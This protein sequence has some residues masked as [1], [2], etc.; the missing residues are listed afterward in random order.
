MSRRLVI[1]IDGTNNYPN[2]GYTNVQ[3]MFR[4]LK[5]DDEQLTYYQ[6]GAGTIEPGS[7]TTGFGR[8]A[9]M[10]LDMMSAVMLRQHVCAA[11]RYLMANYAFGDE[12]Y[13]FGF[14]RGA[15]AVRV[16][17]GMLTKV[18]LLHPGF[19]ELVPYA[20]NT[21]LNPKNA[22]PARDFRRHYAR[23]IDKIAFLGLFD[24]VSAVGLPW[25]PKTFPYTFH[26]PDVL[27]VRHA[28]ALDEHRVMF[29]QNRWKQPDASD[30][31]ATTDVR[32]VWFAGVH[33][34]VGGGYPE[35]EAGLARIP[36]AWMAREAQLAGLEFRP[37]LRAHML[38]PDDRVRQPNV[39]SVAA[40]CHDAQPHDQLRSQPLWKLLELLPIPRR[41]YDKD[42][43]QWGTDWVINLGRPRKL[44]AGAVLHE[45][46]KLRMASGYRPRPDLIEETYEW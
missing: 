15:F 35:A 6:P 19:D 46:V 43:N 44:P 26:N 4:I 10:L 36:F 40:E 8:R 37:R 14:S 34:D 18:G 29:V 2:G 45:S 3:R 31:S 21:Y 9:V 16:L 24:T 17:A 7:M 32:Q 27:K 23:Y 25:T 30:E 42:A 38:D 33:S 28:Q 39:Q 20:W 1:C 41:R 22:E 11:Y 13:F 5:R 12:L